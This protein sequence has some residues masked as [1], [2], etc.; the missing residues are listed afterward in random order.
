M[1][2]FECARCNNL[3]YS[4]S[5]FGSIHCDRCGGSRHRSL[6][7]AYSF[8]EAREEPRTL[9]GGDHCCLGFDD[10]ADVAHLCAHVIRTA[11]A[12][13][14]RVIAH[15]PPDVRAAI[16]PL[17]DPAEA[18]TVEWADSDLLYRPGFDP[19]AS[20][21]AFRAI[22][23][24][25]PRPIYVLGGPGVDLCALMTPEELRRFEHLITQ[26]TSETG[27]VVVCLYDRRLQSA[28]SVE[29]GRETHPLTSDDGGP[30]KRNERFAYVGV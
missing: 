28:D 2:V 22:A 4:A 16:E 10:P 26:G 18:A 17:L 25:E 1:P 9:S 13:G 27:M 11:L 23:D 24:S 19:D 14:A 3:T 21:A 7:H 6:E 29:A 15:P 8:D 5:R 30:I 12:D 20:V